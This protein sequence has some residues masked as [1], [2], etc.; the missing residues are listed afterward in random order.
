MK[1][2]KFAVA[3]AT[4]V[5]VCSLA[6]CTDPDKKIPF[7]DYWQYN[8]LLSKGEET[9]D[10]TLV[11][12][13]AFEKGSGMDGVKYTLVYG[14]GSYTTHLK[15]TAQGYEYTTSL[16]IPVS[17][18]AGT[19]TASFTDSVETTVLFQGA[20]NALRPISSTKTVVSHSPTNTT[21]FEL[22]DAYVAYDF[23]VITTYADD[24]TGNSSVTY[25]TTEATE[26]TET[27]N[28]KYGGGDY[29]YL[30]NEQILLALRAIDKDTS[31]GTI[32]AYNPFIKSTQKISLSFGKA[33]GQ[34]FSFTENGTAV[35]RDIS[36]REVTIKLN[37]LNPGGTQ[38][39]LIAAAS[40]PQKN[41]NRNVMLRLETPLSY[42]LGKLI[43]TLTSATKLGN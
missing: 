28:F 34:S 10:E 19:Q 9:V 24:G 42:S 8:S 7:I 20:G 4:L 12:K 18:T 37:E 27:S 33:T 31:A 6:A 39:A 30:D 22:T 17:Y 43:Y 3:M 25:R 36:H 16:T 21:S 11:Y 32:K 2:T 23:T 29:S 1:A 13:V 15:S 35:T 40:D 38:T 41:T 5:G 26:A 14:D